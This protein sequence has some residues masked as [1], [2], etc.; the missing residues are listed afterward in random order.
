MPV[1]LSECFAAR[2]LARAG[3]SHAAFRV[4]YSIAASIARVSLFLGAALVLLHVVLHMGIVS[5]LGG[6]L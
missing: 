1:L 3:F 4:S 6:S 5:N 2:V